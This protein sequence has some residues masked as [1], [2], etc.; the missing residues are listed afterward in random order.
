[1]TDLGEELQGTEGGSGADACN[2][3][4][5][6]AK[7]TRNIIFDHYDGELAFSKNPCDAIY[8]PITAAKNWTEAPA[9]AKECTM[10]FFDGQMRRPCL[11]TK[12]AC[13]CSSKTF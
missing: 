10:L 12:N 11:I 1:M 13:S 7:E 9:D 6:G 5:T 4:M 3:I 8:S 2:N